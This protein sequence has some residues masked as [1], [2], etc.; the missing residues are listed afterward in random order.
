MSATSPSRSRSPPSLRPP[1][2]RE[3]A[4]ASRSGSST[5]RSRWTKTSHRRA[6][7]GPASTG[8]ATRTDAV[9]V[10][11]HALVA[12]E[13]ADAAHHDRARVDRRRRRSPRP[14]RRTRPQAHAAE[15]LRRR[16]LGRVEVAVGVEPQDH[17]VGA[18]AHERR[19][20]WSGRSSSRERSSTGKCSAG[21]R[22]LDL[23]AGLEQAAARVAQVVGPAAVVR[24]A[25]RADHA[26]L[27]AAGVA[28]ARA[29]APA[30]RARR[31]SDR[32]DVRQSSATRLMSVKAS[33]NGPS[34]PARASRRT[35]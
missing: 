9:G 31:P 6:G 28:R 16:R 21:Q 25:G 11:Q 20:A 7:A 1:G 35:P 12:V 29:R 14:R 19:A 23:A 18:A 24:L 32:S 27:D 8:R 2:G 15:E 30:P 22:V 17:R 10:Q 34:T 13:V 3:R 33:L 26:R 5:S 4:R